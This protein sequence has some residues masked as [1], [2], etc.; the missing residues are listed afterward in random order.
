MAHGRVDN[1]QSGPG[2][3]PGSEFL[4]SIAPGQGL[5]FRAKSTVP[6][7]LWVAHQNVFIE[8]AP[9]Q[10][11]DPGDGADLAAF[12]FTL[13]A[14][15]RGVQALAWRDH[16]GGEVGREL[17]GAGFRREVPLALVVVDLS[18]DEGVEA[19][20]GFGFPGRPECAKAVGR[21]GETFDP[22]RDFITGD[23]QRRLLHRSADKTWQ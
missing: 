12:E 10:F 5:G 23:A 19:T 20:P 4:G 22:G 16:P 13:I 11:I 3:L 14:L 8:L 9:Q 1:R 17:A 2:L 15:Q 6:G 7:H 21:W 18:V